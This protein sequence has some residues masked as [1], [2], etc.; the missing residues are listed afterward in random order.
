MTSMFHIVV[1]L[2]QDSYTV[3]SSTFPGTGIS[4]EKTMA[5][6]SSSL[7]SYFALLD[8][9]VVVTDWWAHRFDVGVPAD[10]L[11]ATLQWSHPHITAIPPS[12]H[13]SMAWQQ[14]SH[15][16]RKTT[17]APSSVPISL[18]NP[19]RRFPSNTHTPGKHG[20]FCPAFQKG[21]WCYWG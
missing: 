16:S 15:Q 8:Q 19:V 21:I 1:H 5:E 12:Q 3:I 18:R 11:T 14:N 7:E 6:A 2:F 10:W 20:K 17:L 9:H 13:I 4:Q